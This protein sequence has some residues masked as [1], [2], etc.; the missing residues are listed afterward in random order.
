MP[1]KQ[2]T[3][4]LFRDTF[5]PSHDASHHL[6]SW[7][8]ARSVLKEIGKYNPTLTP[9]FIEA[10]MVAIFFHDLGMTETRDARH[11]KKSK[12]IYL[13]WYNQLEENRPALHDDILRA[14][15]YHDRKADEYFFEFPL[16]DPPDLLTLVNV[17]DDLDALGVIGIY[18]YAE[19]YLHRK[20]PLSSLGIRILENVALRYNNFSKATA[21][22]PAIKAAHQ[23]RYKEIVTFFDRYNQQ[24]LTES[25]PEDTFSGHVG[26]INYI[27]QLS[28]LGNTHPVD[29]PATLDNFR[30]GSFVREYFDAL[31]QK[32]QSS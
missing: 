10:A 18:R 6:R 22:F 11:G 5:L 23:P 14:I 9:S 17:S 32:M 2:Y 20:V 30:V 7:H 29:I 21:F 25:D 31:A 13:Q 24:I 8:I 27:R 4:T 1:L 28:V 16:K 15:E 3:E 12:E 26:V 19:I